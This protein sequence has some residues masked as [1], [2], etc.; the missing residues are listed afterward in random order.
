MCVHLCSSPVTQVSRSTAC[1]VPVWDSAWPLGARGHHDGDADDSSWVGSVG[2]SVPDRVEEAGEPARAKER[3]GRAQGHWVWR[4]R[5]GAARARAEAM[6]AEA[7]GGRKSKEGW[8][9]AGHGSR[10]RLT[11]EAKGR[12]FLRC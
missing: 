9:A 8:T 12:D 10:Q 1:S 3:A 6:C 7:A 4:R 2:A 11:S 5:G